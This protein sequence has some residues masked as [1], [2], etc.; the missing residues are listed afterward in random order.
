LS[1]FIQISDQH[2]AYLDALPLSD[3]AKDVVS[4]FIEK[5]IAEVTDDFRNNPRNRTQDRHTFRMNLDLLDVPGDWKVH[6]VAFF[7]ND[8][9]VQSGV[10]IITRVEHRLV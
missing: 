8:E 3:T 4:E 6:Q 2:Q 7:V 9:H 5:T 10:L 1:Y